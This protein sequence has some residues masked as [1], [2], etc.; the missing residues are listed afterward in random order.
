[1]HRA[2]LLAL[3]FTA[4]LAACT[5]LTDFDALEGSDPINATDESSRYRAPD[6]SDASPPEAPHDGTTA[7]DAAPLV[8]SIRC[9]EPGGMTCTTPAAVCCHHCADAGE[10]APSWSCIDRE[11]APSC[12]DHTGG[13]TIVPCSDPSACAAAGKPGTLCCTERTG[14]SPA[15]Y[16]YGVACLTRAECKAQSGYDE[17]C[18]PNSAAPCQGDAACALGPAYPFYSC[19]P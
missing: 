4:T 3:F 10:C 17:L 18:D 15:G 9:S 12:V 19:S 14:V 6:G 8:A 5:L 1:M 2:P 16:I 11:N 7:P 13:F